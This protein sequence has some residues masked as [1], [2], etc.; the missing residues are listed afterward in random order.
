[1][2]RDSG[3]D[4]LS[5]KRA[6]KQQ[7]IATRDKTFGLC[8]T[9]FIAREK[10]VWTNP[11]SEHQWRSSLKNA[12]DAFGATPV[13]DITAEDV[14]GVIE[15]I[16]TKT[17]DTSDKLLQRI[18]SVF[19]YAIAQGWRAAANPANRR[20][21]VKGHK[22]PK[23]KPRVSS[24][25]P[26]L[27]YT[28]APTFFRYMRDRT[29]SISAQALE[30]LILTGLKTNE[31]IGGRWNE[32]EWDDKLRIIPRE[33][34]K[35]RMNHHEVP[36]SKGALQVLKAQWKVRSMT[37]DSE[38][39]FPGLKPNQPLSTAA[40]HSLIKPSNGREPWPFTDPRQGNKTIS[41]HGFRSTLRDW[42]SELGKRPEL[43]K[44]ILNHSLKDK[45][46]AAYQRCQLT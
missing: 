10:E 14:I 9:E 15:P 8:A 39:I 41:V 6:A 33:R 23:R 26:S 20:S 1:M 34:T 12:A 3:V 32:I 28:K 45:V 25:H 36:L 13:K 40:M 37:N 19:E 31:L 43:M 24:P 11:K 29:D 5:H 17:P 27:P 22:L 44:K 21:L 42:G 35:T 2:L 38:Y 7:A 46:E 18:S 4:P 16:W 30:L